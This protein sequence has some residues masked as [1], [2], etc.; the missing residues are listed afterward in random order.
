MQNKK[1]KEI[2]TKI[3]VIKVIQFNVILKIHNSINLEFSFNFFYKIYYF[4]IINKNYQFKLIEKIIIYFY[5]IYM[6]YFIFNA[7]N[8][9]IIFIFNCIRIII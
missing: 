4:L 1:N 8:N 7:L 6:I 3:N 2:E 5:Y 9:F